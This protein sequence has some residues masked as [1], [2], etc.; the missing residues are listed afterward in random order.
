MKTLLFILV[1]FNVYSC[2]TNQDN[3][4]NASIQY[5][6]TNGRE[7]ELYIDNQIVQKSTIQDFIILADTITATHRILLRSYTNLSD[8]SWENIINNMRF[9]DKLMDIYSFNKFLKLHLK[10]KSLKEFSSKEGI[11]LLNFIVSSNFPKNLLPYCITNYD[12]NW[13]NVNSKYVVNLEESV[14]LKNII[15]NSKKSNFLTV[16]DYCSYTF[17]KKI[18]SNFDIHNKNKILVCVFMKDSND[19]NKR[20]TSEYDRDDLFF[21]FEQYIDTD[22]YVQLRKKFLNPYSY[23]R[24]RN[25]RFE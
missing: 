12:N 13:E 23:C 22:G 8:C 18:V 24:I 20:Y 25:N 1:L 14:S 4:E 10:L 17:N 2:K 15:D 16:S 21:E 7:I 19:I 9:E 3:L 6:G 11:K 5:L